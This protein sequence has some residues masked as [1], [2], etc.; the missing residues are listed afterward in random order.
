M[1]A[2]IVGPSK[3]YLQKTSLFLR[4]RIAAHKNLLQQLFPT[5]SSRQPQRDNCS[6]TTIPEVKEREDN[7]TAMFKETECK[8]VLP[9]NISS[10][11]GLGNFFSS[12]A[13]TPEQ[14]YDLLNFR[15]IGSNDLKLYI[16]HRVLRQLSTD[17]YSCI[18]TQASYNGGYCNKDWEA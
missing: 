9:H 6:F 5:A 3:A 15:K 14:A 1:K 2:A 4:Y 12:K 10:N 18:A 17:I 11:R 13:A 8:C 7:I 16:Q